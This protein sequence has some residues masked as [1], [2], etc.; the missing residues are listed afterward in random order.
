MTFYTEKKLLLKCLKNNVCFVAIK[1]KWL[2]A[3]FNK[4]ATKKQKFNK[5]QSINRLKGTF[6][7]IILFIILSN[8]K[9]FCQANIISR[10][11]LH[12][13]TCVPVHGDTTQL[14]QFRVRHR[15]SH[16]KCQMESVE[17]LS[18]HDICV[19]VTMQVI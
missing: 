18:H 16:P 11:R 15:L 13:M 12:C 4:N 2:A 17:C 10:H 14:D 19:I 9:Y 6:H 7:L 1:Y 5:Q 8:V 3:I